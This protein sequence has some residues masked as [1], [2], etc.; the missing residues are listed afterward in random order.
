MLALEAYLSIPD[1]RQWQCYLYNECYK[2]SKEYPY[3]N[4]LKKL[5]LL[6]IVGLGSSFCTGMQPELYCFNTASLLVGTVP[7]SGEF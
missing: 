5:K 6:H 3:F 4:Y 1:A 7:M 2:S